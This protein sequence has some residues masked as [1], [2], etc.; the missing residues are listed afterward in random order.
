MDEFKI[1]KTT[2][3]DYESILLFQQK[4][5]PHKKRIKESLAFWRSQSL[6]AAEKNIILVDDKG[7]V[8]GQMF[9]S[10][11]AYY[12]KGKK[13][14]S[15]WEY[16]LFV[17]EYFRKS[18]WGVDLVL[19]CMDLYPNACS[20]GSGPQAL[21]VHLK[22]G[23]KMLGE[24]RKYVRM[25]NPFYLVTSF[26]RGEVKTDGF[27]ESITVKGARYDKVNMNELPDLS[28]PF[29]V[30]YFEIA[31]QKS[32]FEWRFFSGYHDYAFYKE[33]D[34]N[35]FFV[36]RT[37][38]KKGIT[39]LVLV[40]YRFNVSNAVSFNSM[41]N[42][43]RSIAAKLHLSVIICG[44]SFAVSDQVL[45]K[46]GFK[47]IGRPRPIIGFLKCNDRKEDIVNRNFCFVTLADSDGETNW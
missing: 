24:V 1:R 41:V 34:G 45:E 18:A 13:I 6:E 12:Y 22:L 35:D 27:P 16:D 4:A 20:T 37:I 29:N 31:R 28:E 19:Y 40:D 25:G 23:Q 10:D 36:V 26:R 9:V 43:I 42:A 47:S 44:S 32:F 21:P 8:H 39:A 11:M 7:N 38:V 17:E 15:V 3:A 2:S 33:N 5:Y 14:E 30:D 46:H